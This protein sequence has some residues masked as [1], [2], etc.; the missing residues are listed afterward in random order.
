M[1]KPLKKTIVNLYGLPAFGFQVFV[2]LEV[3][4]FAYF[5]TD[6]ALLPVGIAG[7]VM[8]ITSIFDIIW[9][10]TAGVILQKN[11][12]TRWGRY[13]S[14]FLVGPPIAALFYLLQFSKIGSI[15]VTAALICIGFIVSHLIWNVH[16]TAHLSMNSSLTT[17]RE[18]RV[19]MSSN[20]GMFNALGA[21]VFSALGTPLVQSFAAQYGAVGFTYTA[22]IFGV[23]MIACYYIFFFLTSGYDTYEAPSTEDA[24]SEKLSVG[25]MFKQILVN[26]PLIGMFLG[27]IGRYVGRFVIFGLA[28]YYFTHVFANPALLAVF[29]TILN[30][31]LFVGALMSRTIANRIGE[32]NTY[33]LSILI[34]IA[35]L[36]VVY[37]VPMNYIAFFVV[38]F[39]A[40]LGYGMPDGVGVAMYSHTVDYGEWKTGKNAR[41]FI[42]SL[43]SLPIKLAVTFRSIV[44]PIVLSMGGYVAG[45]AT[46]PELVDALR[47]GF[48][49]IPVAFLVF[50]FICIYFLYTITP[51]S[52]AKI[53]QE[54]AE[55]KENE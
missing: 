6:Y 15:N 2:N 38:M 55:R 19:A 26:P 3:M 8:L 27:D 10:P 50:S 33:L 41:G 21:I 29:F 22:A 45:M 14:W 54:I 11:I 7:V 43:F 42:M 30:V 51:E 20:R 34:F 52:L 18:E 23:L 31:A 39:I 5:L 17:V 53:Q 12:I 37:M 44:I 16:Y 4:F 32:R 46:T 47:L 1:D 49:I 48:S 36:L 28:A 24:D 25:E 40:Y 9:V 35:G 13:R